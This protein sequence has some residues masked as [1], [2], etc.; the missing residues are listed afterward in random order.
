M[1]ATMRSSGFCR[2]EKKERCCGVVGVD[3]FET[4]PVELDLMERGLGSVEMIEI[5]DEAL[6][7]TVRIVLEKVPI[8]T[9]SFA[10][11]VALGELLA[12][13]RSFCLDARY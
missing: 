4:V 5:A 2:A 10:P 12:M 1:M 7:G 11:F 13:K 6:D 8:E 9:V 3:P